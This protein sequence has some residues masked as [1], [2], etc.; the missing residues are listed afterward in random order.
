MMSKLSVPAFGLLFLTGCLFPVQ[1]QVDDAICNRSK[2]GF[3]LHLTNEDRVSQKQSGLILIAAQEAKPVNTFEK[4]VTVGPLVPGHEA[5]FIKMPAFNASKEVKA[6]AIKALFPALPKVQADPD[7]PPGPDGKALTLSDLQQIA[8][9][10]SPLLRQATSDIEAA[11]G[12][13]IQAGAFPNPT[14]GYETASAGPSGGPSYG[15]FMSQTFKPWGKLKLAQAAAMMDLTNAEFAHRRAETD[16]LSNVRTSYYAVLVAQESIRANRGL[17]E[18]TDELY[19]VMVDQLRGGE[20]APYEPLQLKVFSEQ[21][22]IG[23]VQARNSRLL[24]WRQLAASLGVPH[25]PATALAGN[26][27]RAVP[28]IDFEKAL[29]H[30]LTKHT[31]VLTTASTIEKARHNLR[32]AQVT[33]YPDVNFQ[34]TVVND[35]GPGGP[36][37][38][39]AAFQVSVPVPIFDQ[40][41]GGIRQSQAALVRANEEPHRVH[42]DLTSRFSEAYR[43]YEENRVLL[44]R[45]Q[46]RILPTQVQAFRAAVKRYSGGDLGGVAF[47]DL[48]SSEQTLVSV[49]GSYLLVVQAQWQA[50]VDVSSLLQTDHLYQVADEVNSGPDIDFTELLTVPC[51][52]PCAPVMPAATR[53]S[54]RMAPTASLAAPVEFAPIAARFATPVTVPTLPSSR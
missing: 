17:V 10:N 35:L 33:P 18:L 22:R 25:M 44:E 24:A 47:T 15:M 28:Q 12:A 32:L 50:L 30:V 34:A 31:D 48:V 39:T 36:S 29:A 45:Y 27:H 51:H 41:K 5:P 20:L 6:A 42:A 13:A 26:I 14:L 54:F 19:R 3:D 37:R 4:R 49:I 9:T 1:Q 43:R 40:N 38:N 8:F 16:L 7:F 23:L 52:R 11:R 21:A 2:I 53:D 46:K